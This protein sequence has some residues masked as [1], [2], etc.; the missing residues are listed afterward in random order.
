[1]ALGP[2]LGWIEGQ[3]QNAVE[4]EEFTITPSVDRLKA[5]VGDS[6]SR[7]LSWRLQLYEYHFL[8]HHQRKCDLSGLN[9]YLYSTIHYG[10]GQNHPLRQ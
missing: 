10:P 1:M 7:R 3:V 4:V 5:T 6:I 2:V 9:Y 8:H